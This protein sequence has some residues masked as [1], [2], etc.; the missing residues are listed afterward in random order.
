MEYKWEFLT[1][2]F[3]TNSPSLRIA[4]DLPGH[5]FGSSSANAEGRPFFPTS[6]LDRKVDDD[7][8]QNGKLRKKKVSSDFFCWDLGYLD[9]VSV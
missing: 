4:L 6:H 7:C 9:F 2:L 1:H 5:G 3:A 8:G